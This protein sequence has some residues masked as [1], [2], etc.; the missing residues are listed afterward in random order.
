[1]LKQWL[2]QGSDILQQQALDAWDKIQLQ[3][4]QRHHQWLNGIPLSAE[5]FKEKQAI[6]HTT[7]QVFD[8]KHYFVVPY[9]LSEHK[10]AL[11]SMRY[12]PSGVP[13]VNDLPKRRVFHFSNPECEGM[14]RQYMQS[15][16]AEQAFEQTEQHSLETL[17]NDIDALDKK[18]TYGM[19]LVGG[20]AVF[21]NPVVA[22]GIMIKG[23]LPGVP[24]LLN[25]YGLKPLGEKLSQQQVQK[26]VEDAK[27]HVAEEFSHANTIKV[28]NPI[29]QHLEHNLTQNLKT[30]EVQYDPLLGPNFSA[31]SLPELGGDY[32][33]GLT[34]KAILDIYRDVLKEPWKYPEA[35]L[36][37]E[38]LRWFEVL[39]AGNHD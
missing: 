2:K 14:L 26:A 15:L 22:A 31:A 32:W 21:V 39:A 23:V 16:A 17:A 9:Y 29:L 7:Q 6:P 19:L 33:R 12:L 1:M 10:F 8:E 13:E 3:W 28:V 35:Q 38:D 5:L 36:T 27:E 24:S 4:H 11:H 20:L 18:L 30:P 34:E 37:P 25:K